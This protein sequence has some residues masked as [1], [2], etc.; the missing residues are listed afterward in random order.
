MGYHFKFK[1]LAEA[2]KRGAR[3]EIAYSQAVVGDSQA[4]RTV[5][6]NATQLIRATR[7]R[8]LVVSSETRRAIECRGPWDV[9]NL[10][11]TWGL[12]QEIGFEAVSKEA[13]GVVVRAGIQQSG[14]RGVVDIIQGLDDK[15]SVH[16]KVYLDEE[17]REKSNPEVKKATQIAGSKRKAEDVDINTAELIHGEERQISKREMKRRAKKAK[18]NA[19]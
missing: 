8:G 15:S 5:I 3:F 2:I 10:L 18:Q 1:P 4:R 12:K 11:A 17:T 16:D 14:W 9:I 7:G 13:R 19:I 6:S